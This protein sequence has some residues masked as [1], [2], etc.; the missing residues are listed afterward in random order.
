MVKTLQSNR[1][2]STDARLALVSRTITTAT[3]ELLCGLFEKA[4]HYLKKGDLVGLLGSVTGFLPGVFLSVPFFTSLNALNESR[5]LLDALSTRYVTPELRR[6]K[7]ILWFTDTLLDLSGVSATLQEL[8]WLT[9]KRGLDL[10]I[11]TC[12]AAPGRAPFAGAAERSRRAR[13]LC[14]YAR[15]FQNLC[16]ALSF[17]A[18][19]AS[20]SFRGDAR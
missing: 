19:L 18:R 17:G 12:L 3:D 15:I 13:H 6:R 5:W 1:D 10:K 4:G 16:A 14:L 9:D 8:A 2:L 7:R 11:V 20:G